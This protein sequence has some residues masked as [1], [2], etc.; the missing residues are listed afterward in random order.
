[1]T[2]P[3]Q[4]VRQLPK[5]LPLPQPSRPPRRRLPRL[6][7]TTLGREV[8]RRKNLLNRP[9]WQTPLGFILRSPPPARDEESFFSWLQSSNSLLKKCLWLPLSARR[10]RTTNLSS[11]WHFFNI[12]AEPSLRTTAEP[13]LQITFVAPINPAPLRNGGRGISRGNGRGIA[14]WASKEDTKIA[15][16]GQTEDRNLCALGQ[17]AEAREKE[18]DPPENRHQPVGILFPAPLKPTC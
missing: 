2:S 18:E 1:M 6:A 3:L 13:P 12:P 7:I 17:P 16:Q 5:Y 8:A 11:Q 10:R 9:R 15:T 4:V 14:P